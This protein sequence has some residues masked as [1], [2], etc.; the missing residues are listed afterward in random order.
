M[1]AM[2]TSV[3]IYVER[4]KYTNIFLITQEIETKLHFMLKNMCRCGVN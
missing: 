1:Q 2:P 4:C 3:I